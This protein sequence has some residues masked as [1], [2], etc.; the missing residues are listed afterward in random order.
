MSILLEQ[1]LD[2]LVG[3]ERVHGEADETALARDCDQLPGHHAATVISR[4]EEPI[5]RIR[6]GGDG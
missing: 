4:V 6:E 3:G 2:R 5:V 1:C